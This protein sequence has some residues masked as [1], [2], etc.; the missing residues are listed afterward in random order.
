MR[1]ELEDDEVALVIKPLYEAN[2]EWEGDVATGVAMNETISLD[3]NI[4]RGLVN[5]ITLMTSFL[6]YSD[7]KEELVDEVLKWRDKLFEDLDESPFA[8][9][10]TDKDNNIITLTKFTK[11]KGSA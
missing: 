8:E 11:T 4:Q 6:S 1:Y 3:I 9:Y 7:D 10:E 5:I 2:G